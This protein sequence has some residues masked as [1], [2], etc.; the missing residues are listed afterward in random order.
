[1]C[2]TEERPFPAG[3]AP[4]MAEPAGWHRLTVIPFPEHLVNGAGCGQR[5]RACRRCR[6]A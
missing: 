5:M 4:S 6:C 3:M 1:M 2:S